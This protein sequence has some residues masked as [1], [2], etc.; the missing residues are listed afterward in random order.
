MKQTIHIVVI[1]LVTLTQYSTALTAQQVTKQIDSLIPS[2]GVM[3]DTA[4]THS[5][6]KALRRSAMLPGWGQVYN[7]QIWKVPIIYTALGVTAGVFSYNIKTYKEVRFAYN[8]KA[9]L[10]TQAISRIKPYLQ[11]IDVN[12]LSRYRRTFRQQIDYSVLFF[13][14]FWGLNCADAIV[15]AHLKNFDVSNNVSGKLTLGQSSLA[16]TTGLNLQLS[17]HP[18][19]YKPVSVR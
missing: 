18:R 3:L 8:A 13:L 14:G 9:K 2:K 1:I 7:K 6:K 16:S 4:T 19:V 15:F 12:S 11:N 5:P 17:L 10:D